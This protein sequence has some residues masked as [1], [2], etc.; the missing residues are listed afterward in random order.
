M[1]YSSTETGVFVAFL[2]L[3][4]YFSLILLRNSRNN[5]SV[6][7]S[8]SV[9]SIG[10]TYTQSTCHFQAIQAVQRI[11]T[12]EV[13]SVAVEMSS[14]GLCKGNHRQKQLQECV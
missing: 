1:R 14:Y 12:S 13:F 10:L 9:Y 5:I 6:S 7:L 11:Q 2:T 8:F 3:A 4:T